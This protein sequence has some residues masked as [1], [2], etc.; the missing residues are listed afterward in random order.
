MHRAA[1]ESICGLRVQNGRACVRPC[2]PSHWPEV[3]LHLRHGGREHLSIVCAASADAA[4][5][6][7]LAA[8]A[9]GAAAVPE[10]DTT[11]V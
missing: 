10:V 4:I 1:V 3:R 8:G 6:S 9:R 2:L 5:A 11:G 7:A